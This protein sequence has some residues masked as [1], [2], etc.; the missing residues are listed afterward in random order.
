LTLADSGR[1]GAVFRTVICPECGLV[2]SDPAP[3]DIKD[4]YERAYRL[5][6]KG[7]LVPKL[8]HVH[9][10]ALVAL[11]RYRRSGEFLTPG[12][13]LLDM[14]SGGGEFLYLMTRLGLSAK[15]VEPNTGYAEY[16]REELGLDVSV[17][18]IQDVPLAPASLD[19]VTV[20]HVLEHTENPGDILRRLGEAIAEGGRLII[21]VP[22]VKARCQSPSGTF[23][24]AHLFNFSVNTLSALILRAGLAVERSLLS[25]DGGN[26]TVIARREA[27]P[28]AVPRP[29]P[30]EAAETV[31][32]VR[33]RGLLS[34]ALSPW[35]FRRAWGKLKR[36]LSERWRPGRL[37]EGP[38]ARRLI[39]DTLYDQALGP[40]ETS[41]KSRQN[42]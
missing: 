37:K 11:E 19:V 5:E 9:R 16:S 6:Y 38:G 1:G 28:P 29:D 22:N 27:S 35:P 31:E 36:A 7:V 23:H 4:F 2:F 30:A 14:G 15:G 18:F 40:A 20:W 33:G 21:E 17:G 41:A 3:R 10:A 24:V 42:P 12:V 25:R 32:I 26:L 34:Y 13:R 39:L 8:K